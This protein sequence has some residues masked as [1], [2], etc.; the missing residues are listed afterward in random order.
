MERIGRYEILSEL[1]RGAM[2]VVYL[3]RDPKIGREVAI[4]TIK[5]ADKAAEDEIEAL[6]NRLVREA[7]SAGRLSHPGIVTIYDVDEEGGVSYIAMEY[8]RG[9]TLERKLRNFGRIED[10]SFV[11][12][13]LTDTAEAL[14]YAHE[15]GII[16]RDVKPGNV[17]LGDDG[18]VKIM[19]FG[20]ARVGST[21]L[22]QTGTVMGTPS[23]MSPEQVKGEDLDGRSDQFSLGVIAYEMLTGKKPFHGDNLTSVIYKIVSSPPEPTQVA[24]PWVAPGVDAVVMR[25]LSKE[26]GDRFASCEAFALAFAKAI[27]PAAAG[28]E[29]TQDLESPAGAIDPNETQPIQAVGSATG[30]SA[31][32]AELAATLLPE[33]D[34]ASRLPPLS[35]T[36]REIVEES[37]RH[38]DASSSTGKRIAIAALVLLAVGVGALIATNP[39]FLSD[40]RAAI[41]A[42]LGGRTEPQSMPEPLAE[43]VE[44]ETA[45]PVAATPGPAAAGP[46][47][48]APAEAA[49]PQPEATPEPKN[50]ASAEAPEPE[51]AA[52]EPP[53][54]APPEPKPQPK[55]VAKSAPA[56]PS[57]PKTVS[58][59]FR[60]EPI[61]A[62]I[63][64][65]NR[66]DWTCKT[67]CRLNDLPT[68]ARQVTAKLE[69]YYTAAR[70]VELG[71]NEQEIV[72]LRL[73]DARVTA[74][75]TSEPAG[76]EIYIDGRKQPETTNAKIPLPRGT[77]QVKVV[78][79]GVG[80]AEQ[81]LVVDK[82]QI[83]FAKFVL[84]KTR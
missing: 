28:A 61:G 53:A 6:R 48:A 70:R 72:H 1:G 76:A 82:D 13:V 51:P 67:P 25:A 19:D 29:D 68:G 77:Y 55:P 59:Y 2:G 75:I 35:R 12:H 36:A 45:P 52:P 27:G 58:V 54:P 78:K 14:D 71:A 16:H 64:V 31:V 17:M 49:T 43:T 83:P 57:A 42:L 15:K 10:L 84:G 46:E 21:K 44:P 23:Y 18:A 3:A 20:I 41:Q 22:T 81:V 62:E 4:K 50:E 32:A 8:V 37:E 40:P 34:T 26:P 56:K 5:L 66:P 79:P 80:E 73:E 74:L 63:T 9:E 30:A 11:S 7:Q 38:E 47:E 69:G 33:N 65:D 39:L 60:T 24:A